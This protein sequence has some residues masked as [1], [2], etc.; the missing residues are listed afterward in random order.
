MPPAA[1]IV[2]GIQQVWTPV[3]GRNHSWTTPIMIQTVVE[4]VRRGLSKAKR[5][6]G[7]GRTDPGLLWDEAAQ[8][9]APVIR[10]FYFQAPEAY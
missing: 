3:L 8:V 7:D 6:A 2:E 1:K 4:E 5:N 9:V 10:Q